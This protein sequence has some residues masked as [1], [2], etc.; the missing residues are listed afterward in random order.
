MG[1]CL[2]GSAANEPQS[3]QSLSDEALA[4]K[5]QAQEDK[6]SGNSAGGGPSTVGRQQDSWGQAGAGTKLGGSGAAVESEEEKRQRAL[7][8]AEKRQLNQ[9]GISPEKVKEM[10]EKRKKEELLGKIAEYYNRKKLEM[11][12]GLNAG[13]SEQLKKHWEM[14]Q[15]SDPIA[16]SS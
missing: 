9:P 12:M 11:P 8:A 10:N 7:E 2:K 6:R 3:K 1:C 5:L 4:R 16:G 13:T 14:L 15:S